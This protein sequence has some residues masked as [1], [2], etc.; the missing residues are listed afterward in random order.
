[1]EQDSAIVVHLSQIAE[2]S[3]ASSGNGFGLSIGTGISK[4]S[5]GTRFGTGGPGVNLREANPAAP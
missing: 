1:M 5:P 2:V 4:P 3:G